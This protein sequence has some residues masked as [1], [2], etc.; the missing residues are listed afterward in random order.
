MFEDKPAW[1]VARGIL[2]AFVIIFV[3]PPII[4]TI[5]CVGCSGCAAIIS[6]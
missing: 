4:G 1:S 6:N 5:G 2:I 3:L